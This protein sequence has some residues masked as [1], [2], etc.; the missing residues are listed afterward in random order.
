MCL[1]IDVRVGYHSPVDDM[2]VPEHRGVHIIEYH[3]ADEYHRHHASE[4]GT[5]DV[6]HIGL[7]SQCL[8]QVVNGTDDLAEYLVHQFGLL[9]FGYVNNC[10]QAFSGEPSSLGVG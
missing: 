9:F 10:V 8:Q 4:S 3:D 1:V 5:D 7:Y 2:A 6:S